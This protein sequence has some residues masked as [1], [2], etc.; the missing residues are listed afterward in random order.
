[1]A[2]TRFHD[3][4]CRIMKKNQQTVDQ[5]RWILDVPGN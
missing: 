4:P 1:M 2:F 3:D 5:A